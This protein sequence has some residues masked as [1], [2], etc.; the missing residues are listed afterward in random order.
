MANVQDLEK[1]RMALENLYSFLNNFTEQLKQDMASYSRYVDNLLEFG[2]S[3]QS[4][5]HYQK[6]FK[7]PLSSRMNGVIAGIREHD[8]PYLLENI[9]LI[10]KAIEQ[11]RKGGGEY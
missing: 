7:A 5:D 11:A 10:E 6:E 9:K 4:Y 8:F 2:V 1:Q 3:R